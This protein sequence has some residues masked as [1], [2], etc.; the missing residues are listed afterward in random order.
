MTTQRAK[1]SQSHSNRIARNL[2]DISSV[3]TDIE[4]DNEIY[5]CTLSN[6][7]GA[8]RRASQKSPPPLTLTPH[9][10]FFFCPKLCASTLDELHNNLG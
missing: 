1:Q 10:H 8:E 6:R 5:S 2:E 3:E 9:T 7:D 4:G